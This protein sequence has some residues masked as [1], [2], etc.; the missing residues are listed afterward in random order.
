MLILGSQG[1]ADGAVYRAVHDVQH[2]LHRN[3]RQQNHAQDGYMRS[4]NDSRIHTSA[5]AL[6]IFFHE[7]EKYAVAR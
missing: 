6:H 4:R 5:Q 2:T 3:H 1:T 7:T